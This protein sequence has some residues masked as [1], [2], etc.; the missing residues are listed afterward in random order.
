MKEIGRND[1]CPCGSGKKYKKCCLKKYEELYEIGYKINVLYA[2]LKSVNN[3]CLK[4]ANLEGYPNANFEDAMDLTITSNGLSLIKSILDFLDLMLSQEDKEKLEADINICSFSSITNALNLRNIIECFALINMNEQ[5]D[6]TDSQK[7]LFVEQYKLIEYKLYFEDGRFDEII[8]RT[9]LRFRY[10]MG[11]KKFQSVEESEKKIERFFKTRIPFLCQKNINFNS[12]IEKYCPEYLDFYVQLSKI[13]HPISYKSCM[14]KQYYDC[15]LKVIQKLSEIY[16]DVEVDMKKELP[17]FAELQHLYQRTNAVTYKEIVEIQ[18]KS[19]LSLAALIKDKLDDSFFVVKRFFIEI[20]R[21]LNDINFDDNLGYCENVKI[22]FKVIAEMFAC[23]NKIVSEII[24]NRIHSKQ[25]LLGN[26]EMLRYYEE[27]QNKRQEKCSTEKDEQAYYDFYKKYF[28]QSNIDLNKFLDEFKKTLGFM[29]DENGQVPSLEKLVNDFFVE[30]YDN[31]KMTTI[32]VDNKKSNIKVSD[33]YWLCYKESNNMSHGNGYLYFTN[34][35]AW[36]DSVP[37]I[38]FFD[39]ALCYIMVKLQVFFK[40]CALDLKNNESIDI[41]EI[42]NCF[43][44]VS[45]ALLDSIKIMKYFEPI[46]NNLLAQK[47]D[48]KNF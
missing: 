6:I 42:S 8:D 44:E 39:T 13:V 24:F 27:Y 37:V 43:M 23:F 21:V 41:R 11:L 9:D 25:P 38:Q 10:L 5:G 26:V 2:K 33:F 19:L 1:P 31:T 30:L 46:K 34:I 47:K 16:G 48:C 22:K 18:Q 14:D 36:N 28:P 7:M 45:D 4:K 12:L 17:Y 20:V 3:K 29:I 40:N 32:E 15:Y 35:G